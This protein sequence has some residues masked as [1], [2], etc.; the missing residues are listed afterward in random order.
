MKTTKRE[1][2]IFTLKILFL[3][4]D[5]YLLLFKKVG[6]EGGR[7]RERGKKGRKEGGRESTFPF[8]FDAV[9]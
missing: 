1:C 6:G 8:F 7:G 5:I 4:F 3:F 9:I 2:S